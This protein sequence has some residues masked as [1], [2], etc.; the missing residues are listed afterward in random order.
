[1]IPLQIKDRWQS[2]ELMTKQRQ[3]E[4]ASTS[5]TLSTVAKE[6]IVASFLPATTQVGNTSIPSASNTDV[7]CASDLTHT[8]PPEQTDP[9]IPALQKE[10]F[11]LKSE[12]K[13]IHTMVKS[14]G[15]GYTHP[16]Q[17][18]ND[19]IAS[20]ISTMVE[21]NIQSDHLHPPQD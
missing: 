6:G 2:E 12:L 5:D 7:N 20:T 3:L 21:T 19:E 17:I 1:M 11:D 4:N 13:E 15:Q 18:I 9:S 14:L 10:I 8:N 16:A